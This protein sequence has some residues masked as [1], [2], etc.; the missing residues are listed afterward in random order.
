MFF[1]S[2]TGLL[3]I[4]IVG[5]A[6][7]AALIL[8]LRISGKRTLA[9]MNAFDLVVT[10]ALGS[11][12]ATTLLSKDVALAEGVLAFAVLIAL[13]YAISW[14]AVRSR[15][16]RGLV[17]SEPRLLFHD[18]QFLEQAMRRERVTEAEIRAA[19]RAQRIAAM[20][21]VG[22]VVLETDG[23]FAVVQTSPES[24]ASALRG[25]QRTDSRYGH[26]GE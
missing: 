22:A 17:K 20:E 2:W 23:S 26:F 16:V 3:R 19:V 5:A 14:L 25:V 11:A 24:P 6:A 7:Y 18:G 15:Y 4:V 8:L 13:Q 1:Q 9:K 21:Q 10:V 12:F